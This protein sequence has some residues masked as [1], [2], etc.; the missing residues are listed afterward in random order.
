MKFT[1]RGLKTVVDSDDFRN[2]LRELSSYAANIRQ[3]R[4]IV[5]L[6]AKYLWRRGFKVALEKRKCDLVVD[7]TPIEFKFCFDY[8]TYN[9]NRELQRFG[10]D[11]RSLMDA[12]S[13]KEVSK[14][15]TVS[16]A[17]YKD[18]VEKRPDIFVWVLCQR[19]LSQLTDDELGRVCIAR[20][21]QWYSRI[22][23]DHS[24]QKSVAIAEQFLEKLRGIRK[25]S[26]K[27]GK[28]ATE[29]AFPSVYHFMIC[30]FTKAD[31]GT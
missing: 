4:P 29:G 5:M 30:D 6:V 17:I 14:T 22:H 20:E 21:Q 10:G 3:E 26:L 27:K 24:N 25:F 19:D 13:R 8:D 11:I 16:P 18:V 2:E 12:V 28:I 7:D 1:S 23:A 15:W 9:L 31:T